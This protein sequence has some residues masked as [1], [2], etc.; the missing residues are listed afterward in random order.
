MQKSF[1]KNFSLFIFFT[2]IF[3]FIIL[4]NISFALEI[5]DITPKGNN[6]DPF[7][8]DITITFNKNMVPLGV[9]LNNDD[10]YV[11]SEEEYKIKLNN[12]YASKLNISITPKVKCDYRWLSSNKLSCRFDERLAYGTTYNVKISKDTKSLDGDTLEKD[13]EI[14]FTTKLP[15]ISNIVKDNKNSLLK[16]TFTIY[17]DT[18][19][20]PRTLHLSYKGD[21]ETIESDI[22]CKKSCYRCNTICFDSTKTLD[23]NKMMACIFDDSYSYNN[24]ICTVTPKAELPY[25]KDINLVLNKGL[26][27][28]EG[29]IEQEEKIIKTFKLDDS[30]INKNAL[31]KRWQSIKFY[32]YV[33]TLK[34]DI[35]DYKFSYTF[36]DDNNIE[37]EI[38]GVINETVLKEDCMGNY[39]CTQNL[40]NN[41]KMIKVTPKTNL[42]TNK[43]ISFIIKDVKTINETSLPNQTLDEFKTFN[44]TLNIESITCK[45]Y[46]DKNI[47]LRVNHK[48]T[49]LKSCNPLKD[50]TLN[51]NAPIKDRVRV[52]YL[53]N[54]VKK[55]T[56]KKVYI[57]QN[58]FNVN[59]R[60][61]A[62]K[63][64]IKGIFAKDIFNRRLLGRKNFIFTFGDYPKNYRFFRANT[65]LEKDVLSEVPI[66]STNLKDFVF[67]YK[68]VTT[69]GEKEFKN[70]KVNI[71]SI[72]NSLDFVTPLGIR[73]LL[74]GKS[75]VVEGEFQRADFANKNINCNLKE[76][77][78]NKYCQREHFL[79]QV[80]PFHIHVKLGEFKSLV[81]V[82]DFENGEPQKNVNVE[83]LLSNSKDVLDNDKKIIF[84]GT[85]NDEGVLMLPGTSDIDPTLNAHEIFRCD[86]KRKQTLSVK[87]TNGDDIG[88]LPLNCRFTDDEQDLSYK[89]GFINAWGTTAQG[90][91]KKGDSVNLKIIVRDENNDSLS[92]PPLK[93][94]T[95]TIKDSMDNVVY[96][97]KDVSLSEFG[98]TSLIYD[99]SKTAYTGTYYV[100]LKANFTKKFSWEPLT[101]LVSDF[102]P[103]SFK[104]KSFLNKDELKVGETA[105]LDINATLYAGGPLSQGKFSVFSLVRP[106]TISAKSKAYKD[107]DFTYK[108]VN[109]ENSESYNVIRYH[110]FD[111]EVLYSE[112]DLKLDEKG[113][114][115]LL[116]PINS[117]NIPYGVVSFETRVTD[118]RGKDVTSSNSA[119]YLSMDRFLGVNSKEWLI[120]K[121]KEVSPE[122]IVIND[123]RELADNETINVE[124]R[125]KDLKLINEKDASSVYKERYIKSWEPIKTCTLKFIG[126]PLSCDFTPN[127]QGEYVLYAYI[128]DS[129]KK[130]YEVSSS[131]YAIN[132]NKNDESDND[133]VNEGTSDDDDELSVTPAQNDY[134]VGEV[135]KVLIFNPYPN[136]YALITKERYGVK[137]SFVKLLKG[138]SELIEI[139]V[140]EDDFPGFYVSVLVMAKRVKDAETLDACSDDMEAC[141]YSNYDDDELGK[142]KVKLGYAKITVKGKEKKLNIDIKTDKDVYRPK[143]EVKV[144]IS[145]KDSTERDVESELGIIVLDE[146][147]FDLIEGKFNYFD[148]FNKFYGLLKDKDIV[149]Y[150]I[151]KKLVGRINFKKGITQGGGGGDES[152]S[153]L[154]SDF[155]YVA[156][157]NPSAITDSEGKVKVSF[158]L[159]DNLT[160]FKVIVFGVDKKDKMGANETSFKVN[161]ET[162]IRS[163]MPNNVRVGDTFNARWT[164]LNRNLKNKEYEVSYKISDNGNLNDANEFKENVSIK[165][166]ERFE[167]SKNVEVKNNNKIYYEIIAK[168]KESDRNFDYLKG[169]IKVLSLENKKA[170]NFFGTL[171]A[172]K[173]ANNNESNNVTLPLILPDNI[174]DGKLSFT[175]STSLLSTLDGMFNYMKN[176]PHPCFEQKISRALVASIYNAEKSSAL[177]DFKWNNAEKFIN[178]VLKEAKDYQAPNG[179]MCFFV[180]RNDNASTYLSAYSLIA[181]KYLKDSGYDVPN[182]V[183]EKIKKYLINVLKKDSVLSN[184]VVSSYAL[185][186]WDALEDSEIIRL[187]EKKDDLTVSESAIL[188]N[189]LIKSKNNKNYKEEIKNILISIL[190]TKDETSGKVPFKDARTGY[191]WWLLDSETKTNCMVLNSFI[192]YE[193]EFNDNNDLKETISKLARSIV[194]SLNKNGSWLN[195]QENVFCLDAINK[196]KK[197]YEANDVNL[198][199]SI[200]AL[201]ANFDDITLN[202]ETKNVTKNILLN[203]DYNKK[204]DEFKINANGRGSIYYNVKTAVNLSSLP[205]ESNS[206]IMVKREYSVKRN[207]TF[208]VLKDDEILNVGDKIRVD[209]YLHLPADRSFVVVS[210]YLPGCF[211]P[212]N[213]ALNES[214]GPEN[215]FIYEKDSYKNTKTFWNEY[216]FYFNELLHDKAKFYSEYLPAGNYHLSYM[217]QVVSK[218]EFFSLGTHAE[219]MYNE[220]V[221]GK[222]QSLRVVVK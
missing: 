134:K 77:R 211:E 62:K 159:P 15:K 44:D 78:N 132:D 219:E 30:Y 31:I 93:G 91:Y 204:Q 206:G 193:N 131:F 125:Y 32:E 81:W 37:K 55:S 64:K 103:A 49:N 13:Y 142:P 161:K 106:R 1:F 153:D 201:D 20:D 205:K 73:K 184:R 157:F 190:N 152:A 220:D 87:V 33:L 88:I 52:K 135:A 7:R 183:I 133:V 51:F 149:N 75:G 71:P 74:D 176:Y 11:S 192:N 38:E 45:N 110:N 46:K 9:S 156:Y 139:P 113:I 188:L 82:T 108:K 114:S 174:N 117:Y 213:T 48:L 27:T 195:T 181:F 65:V 18:I 47:N 59:L 6:I 164:I 137:E 170:Q 61:A 3:Q 145:V 163:V 14:S 146:S 66:A 54:N 191:N 148:P 109:W 210:D 67:N 98:T 178:K 202:N 99:I 101:F 154:R 42:P 119:K 179:A 198:N 68:V 180:P 214:L 143:D 166:F 12:D 196:Y 102:T 53:A 150:N 155:K 4:N 136:S 203:K 90:V 105:T 175:L 173:N 222:A 24:L 95:V 97:N 199:V 25:N 140:K 92:L 172:N 70:V 56:A 129:N 50:I 160:S 58:T 217:V 16:D 72:K 177:N 182:D 147:V 2:F 100:Y 208:K 171:D 221:F 187:Y 17:T 104:V 115:K 118:E 168:D 76:N 128:E 215:N 158:K 116:I 10:G 84:S 23:V 122:F 212:I 34:S 169:D 26:K 36:K 127:K 96:E 39:A 21:F 107:F 162:E 189:E 22:Q 41:I 28:F 167:I 216:G 165:P 197:H 123:K 35:K 120:H 43:K 69:S 8:N 194:S 29:N 130:K 60:N 112:Y 89:Y 207:G 5:S 19:I 79:S 86:K 85:T 186:K 126:E 57:N 209:L 94:Y 144:D 111:S 80:S 63:I 185:L 151:I 40:S 200:K 124:I 121:G 138:A 141:F 218:G 83:V